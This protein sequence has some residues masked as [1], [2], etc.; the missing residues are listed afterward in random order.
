VLGDVTLGED[1]SIFYNCT[2]RADINHITIGSRTNIQ[3][4]TVIHV[5]TPTGVTIG[6]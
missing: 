3:D 5:S 1:S 6:M 2:V 4:N